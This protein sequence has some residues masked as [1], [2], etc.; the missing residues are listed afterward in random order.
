MII[1]VIRNYVY[2]DGIASGN[3]DNDYDDDDWVA[4]GK[5][6]QYYSDDGAGRAADNAYIGRTTEYKRNT[7]NNDIVNDN[8]NDKD[9][10][11][12]HDSNSTNTNNARGN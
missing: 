9:S 3:N 6:A 1:V 12:V 2:G 11:N 5:Y 7:N 4:R 8:D 10:D